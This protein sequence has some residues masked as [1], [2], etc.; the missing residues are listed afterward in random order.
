MFKEVV[1]AMETGWMAYV[2]LFAFLLA[3]TLIVIRVF[4]MKKAERNDLKNMPLDEGEEFP[5]GA[6]PAH[7]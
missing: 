3:F 4:L 6:R 5:A 1:R 7:H 2:G